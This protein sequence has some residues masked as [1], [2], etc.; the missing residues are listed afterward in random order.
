M[1]MAMC[2]IDG[3]RAP[4][5]SIRI[6]SRRRAP[7]SSSPETNWLEADAS[8]ITRPPAGSPP[9]TVNGMV[10]RPSSST[11]TPSARR[12]RIVVA[13]GRARARGS[14]SKRTG[15]SASAATGGRKRISVPAR[16][17]SISVPPATGP[18]SIRRSPS[19]VRSMRAPSRTR[20]ST[21]SSVSRATSG[22]RRT[23]GPCASAESTSSRFVR[24]FEPGRATTADSGAV[25]LGADHPA[26]TE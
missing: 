19:A 20:A 5:C 9:C 8:I 17:Q 25:A 1:V 24:L 13:I 18:G 12:D 22:R 3:S 23:D 26:D 16:P 14:P 10:P 7:T 2:G 15:P 4:R 11:S 6:P 21:M